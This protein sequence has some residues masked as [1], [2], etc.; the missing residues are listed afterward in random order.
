MCCACVSEEDTTVFLVQNKA[1]M[2][3]C[4]THIPREEFFTHTPREEFYFFPGVFF[5]QAGENTFNFEVG[6]R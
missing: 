5:Y 3:I 4:H 1:G 6:N 2:D